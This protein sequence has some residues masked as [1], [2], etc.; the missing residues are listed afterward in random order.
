M[1][2]KLDLN[3]LAELKLLAEERKLLERSVP[4]DTGPEIL[5]NIKEYKE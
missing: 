4:E 5:D 3:S 2:K 1:R